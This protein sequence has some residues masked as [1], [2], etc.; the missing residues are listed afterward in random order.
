MAASF[1]LRNKLLIL[2]AIIFLLFL[3]LNGTSAL[4]TSSKLESYLQK[5]SDREILQKAVDIN[6]QLRAVVAQKQNLLNLLAGNVNLSIAL[7]RQRL[8]VLDELFADWKKESDFKEFLLVDQAGRRISHNSREANVSFAGE[9]WYQELKKHGIS[10]IYFETGG[11]TPVFWLLSPLTVRNTS[12]ALLAKL[13]WQTVPLFLD[14]SKLIQQ[15]DKNNFYLI[16]DDQYNLLYLPPFLHE[17]REAF[18][19]NFFSVG[20]RFQ[21]LRDALQNKEI[22]N[23]HQVDFVGQG[24]CVGFARPQTSPWLVLSLRN[25]KQNIAAIKRIYQSSL[26]VNLLILVGGLGVLSFLIWKVA[27][28]FQQLLGVTEEIISGKYPDQIK[29]PADDEIRQIIEALNVMISQVRQQEAE[30]K[31]LYE[32][33][34]KDSANLTQANELL[35]RQSKELQLKNQEVQQAFDELR[36]VQEDLLKAERLAVVGETSGRVAHEV[37][38]PVTAILFRVENDLAKYPEIHNSLVGL[39]EILG[40][41]QQELENNTLPQYFSQK[42]EDGVLYGEEDLALLRSMANEFQVLNE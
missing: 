36:V 29:I 19:G 15:Q 7:K 39:Q 16:L 22:G 11:A 26:Q 28:P 9:S 34:K 37:L 2:S 23:L 27:A 41:W 40:D 18:T 14:Q 42:G 12:Y 10:R 24:N 38:N 21:A 31:A 25:E 20:R 30:V 8:S 35:A 32:Q 13:D 17:V 5:Q 4:I 33:E 3:L 6:R 1:R